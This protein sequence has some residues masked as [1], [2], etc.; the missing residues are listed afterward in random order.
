MRYQKYKIIGGFG[1]LRAWHVHFNEDD[2]YKN[3]ASLR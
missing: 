3:I 1:S 2:K